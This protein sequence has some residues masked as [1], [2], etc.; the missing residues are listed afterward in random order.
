MSEDHNTTSVK[1]SVKK[2]KKDSVLTAVI[3]AVVVFLIGYNIFSYYKSSILL[4]GKTFTEVSGINPANGRSATINFHEGKVIVNF[5]ATWCNGCVKEINVFDNISRRA[6]VVGIL[7]K[8]MNPR[9]FSS[10]RISYENVVAEDTIFEEMYISFLPTTLL[11]K[12][13]VIK[14]VHTGPVTEELLSGWLS[15]E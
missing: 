4:P 1:E 7:K 15:N 10:L 5:W 13:G 9:E 8:P 11:V 3:I 12:D 6:K 2:S 14:K